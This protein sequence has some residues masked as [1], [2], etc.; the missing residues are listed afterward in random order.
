[1]VAGFGGKIVAPE[2][3]GRRKPAPTAARNK[4][5]PISSRSN[6]LMKMPSGLCAHGLS[7]SIHWGSSAFPDAYRP[8]SRAFLNE[9]PAT[10]AGCARRG[11]GGFSG[12]DFPG[13]RADRH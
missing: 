9:N 2:Q 10:A 11:D 3:T 8:K 6:G 5:G 13:D 1:M 7:R 12:Q 4:L